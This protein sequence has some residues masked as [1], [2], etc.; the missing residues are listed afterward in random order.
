MALYDHVQLN[1]SISS[2]VLL[3]IGRVVYFSLYFILWLHN[4][5]WC[6]ICMG[7]GSTG[8]SQWITGITT[9]AGSSFSLARSS[10][11]A[12]PPRLFSM[13]DIV[14]MAS[15]LLSPP[16]LVLLGGSMTRKDHGERRQDSDDSSGGTDVHTR[17]WTDASDRFDELSAHDLCGVFSLWVCLLSSRLVG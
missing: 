8:N 4:P 5:L 2:E 3:R 13:C 15:I 17:M 1:S 11:R 7:I 12:P 6:I 16:M 9:C 10:P 14:H